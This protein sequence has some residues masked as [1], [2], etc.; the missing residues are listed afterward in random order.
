M[1]AVLLVAQGRDDKGDWWAMDGI[2]YTKATDAREAKT[3]FEKVLRGEHPKGT[4]KVTEH[5]VTIR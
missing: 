2:A 3:L 5:K 1:K 4:L